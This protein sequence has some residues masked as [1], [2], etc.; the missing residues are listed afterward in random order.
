LLASVTIELTLIQTSIQV[1][2][3]TLVCLLLVAIEVKELSI[4]EVHIRG[5]SINLLGIISGQL[6][7]FRSLVDIHSGI[8]TVPL[9]IGLS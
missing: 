8:G 4:D 9:K 7:Y 5:H 3:K 2:L 6:E 1:E